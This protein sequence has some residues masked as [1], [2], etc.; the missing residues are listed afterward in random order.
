MS[1]E[2]VEKAVD[3]VVKLME[4]GVA[5]YN[6]A[7][8]PDEIDIVKE[9]RAEFVSY[10][11]SGVLPEAFDNNRFIVEAADKT[12]HAQV[13]NLNRWMNLQLS[14]S[15]ED[16][17]VERYSLIYDIKPSDWLTIAKQRIIPRM[18]TLGLV[19]I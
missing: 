2:M 17:S 3:G 16:T 4:A 14:A 10:G 8:Q 5:A 15:E 13:Y 7:R 6:T 19:K 9:V 1:E 12:S 18:V 11:L